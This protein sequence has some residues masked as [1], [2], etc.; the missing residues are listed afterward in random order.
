MPVPP[1]VGE[2]RDV[3][4]AHALHIL[5]ALVHDAGIAAETSPHV[6]PVLLCCVA[7]FGSRVWPVR[8]AALQLFGA[9]APRM[10]GQKKVREEGSA[11]NA[12][13]VSEFLSRHA[14]V[15]PFLLERLGDGE[16]GGGE[17]GSPALV[18]NPALVPLLSILCR[19]S[20][21]VDLDGGGGEGGRIADDFKRALFPHLGSPVINVRRLS[22]RAFAAFSLPEDVP[23]ELSACLR[24]LA[25]EDGPALRSAN[26]A[27]GILHCCGAL[28]DARGAA[29]TAAAA[30]GD[31]G[32]SPELLDQVLSRQDRAFPNCYENRLLLREVLRR[33]GRLPSESNSSVPGPGPGPG[34][35]VNPGFLRWRMMS[36]QSGGD[37]EEAAEERTLHVLDSEKDP[38]KLVA[39]LNDL[40]ESKTFDALLAGRYST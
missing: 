22:A 7:N 3:P 37:G 40:M 39:Y 4:Q 33:L 11:C 15:V 14:E 27:N 30:R 20:P 21:A 8:N 1:D 9:L 28:L 16:G 19:L 18:V 13:S 12:L 34:S 36:L 6:H 10:L 24:R 5:R 29:A 25:G 38:A 2:T 26:L 23:S 35:A 31:S 17:D 32:H